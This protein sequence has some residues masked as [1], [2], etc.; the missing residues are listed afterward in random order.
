MSWA[1][2]TDEELI[3]HAELAL[4]PLTSTDLERELISR[5]E[6]SIAENGIHSGMLELLEEFDVET[7]KTND[8]ER[9]RTALQFAADYD[10]PTVRAVMEAALEFDI[11][12]A[13]ALKPMLQIADQI[14]QVRDDA[15]S[16]GIAV[17]NKI[18]NPETVSA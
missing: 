18:F 2:H 3:R 5:F 17:L 1:K 12:T 16:D 6:A 14:A 9:V 13:D 15:T 4:D 7:Y 8:I 11:D 10:L